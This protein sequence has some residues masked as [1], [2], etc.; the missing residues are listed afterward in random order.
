MRLSL[1]VDNNTMGSLHGEWGLSLF[2]EEGK[3]KVLFDVGHSQVFLANSLKMGLA[4]EQ[5]NYIALSHGHYDHTWGLV[6]L[7]QFYREQDQFDYQRPTIVSH[8]QAFFPKYNDKG[9]ASGSLLSKEELKRNFP[10]KISRQPQWL[11][12]KLVYLGEI[13]RRNDFEAQDPVGTVQLASNGVEPDYLTEDTALAFK[14]QEGL[15][16]ISGCAHSG[17]CNIIEQARELCGEERILDIIGGFHLLKPTQS[18]MQGTIQ[19]FKTLKPKVIHPCHCTHFSAK[20]ALA[21]VCQVG[22]A[23]VGLQLCFE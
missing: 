3:T 20:M 10:M 4:I 7:L 19:Y 8:P 5:T 21:Q 18:Q 12:S 17:I 23:G 14:A 13:E 11:T 6:H 16:I 22:E 1:L 9:W 15:V 2:I